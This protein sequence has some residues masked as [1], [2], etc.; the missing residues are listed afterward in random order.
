MSTRQTA[1]IIFC[2]DASSSMEPTI[3]AVCEHIETFVR[4]LKGENQNGEWDVRFDFFAHGAAE[5]FLT[6]THIF[7]SSVYHTKS[8]DMIQDLYSTNTAE[9]FFTS[10]V[11]TFVEALRRV[12]PKGDEFPLL[13]LDMCLDFPWRNQQD[14]H[15]VV[16]FLTDEPVEDGVGLSASKDAL[17][18]LIQKVMDLGVLLFLV[19]PE[20]DIFSE[21]SSAD[22]CEWEVAEHQGMGLK[23]LR[24]GKLMRAMAQSIS[25]SQAA[26]PL[27]KEIKKALFGQDTWVASSARPTGR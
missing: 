2:I 10:E 23:N 16:I 19:T 17:E 5:G 8:I 7:G 9:T 13:A 14:S 1:D 3:A 21:V 4:T 25:K 18:P 20:S 22:K 12:E 26:K 6:G 15:R 27:R 24:F 11:E